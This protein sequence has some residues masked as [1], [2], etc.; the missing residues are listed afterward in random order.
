MNRKFHIVVSSAFRGGELR[1]PSGRTLW[2]RLGVLVTGLVAF[3]IIGSV[4]VF[5][6]LLGSILAVVLCIAL[7][8]A[9]LGLGF[10]RARKRRGPFENS[11]LGDRA[12]KRARSH[13]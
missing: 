3:I 12:S 5:A 2:Q 6:V 9:F 7:V 13:E 10:K 4:L 11:L 8:A 1:G